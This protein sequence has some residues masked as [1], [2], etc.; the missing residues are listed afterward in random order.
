MGVDFG[1]I[2][3]SGSWFSYNDEK[4]GQGREA[5]KKLLE[6][7]EALCAELEEKIREKAGLK[8]HSEKD[9]DGETAPTEFRPVPKPTKKK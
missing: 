4:L 8:K 3:K 5:V 1:V 6:E 9:A 2:K 7:D